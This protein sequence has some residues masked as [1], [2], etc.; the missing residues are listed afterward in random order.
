M[1]IK[2]YKNK[3]YYPSTLYKVNEKEVDV[4]KLKEVC[5]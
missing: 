1:E 2:E 3:Q 5:E 4:F